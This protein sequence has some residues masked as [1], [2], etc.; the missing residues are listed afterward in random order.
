MALFEALRKAL[1]AGYGAQEKVRELVDELVEKGELNESEGA[2]LLKEWSEKAE[3][4]TA[5][6]NKLFSDLVSKSLAKMNIPTKGDLEKIDRKLRSL[7]SKVKKLEEKT[8]EL[9]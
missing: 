7:S 5:D 1:L 8:G 4:G 2:R 9:S 3:K 6:M